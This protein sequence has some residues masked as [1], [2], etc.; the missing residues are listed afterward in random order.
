[1]IPATRASLGHRLNQSIVQPDINA[2]NFKARFRNFSPTGEKHRTTWRFFWTRDMK[3]SYRFSLVGGRFG[4]SRFIMGT[5][6]L[7]ISS[8]SSRANKLDTWQCAHKLCYIHLC[9]MLISL[10]YITYFHLYFQAG[11]I[12][13]VSS[14]MLSPCLIPLQMT[15][16]CSCTPE[17]THLWFHCL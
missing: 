10:L 4:N 6:S 16:H 1:M 5:R 15:G 12:N 9:Q 13:N 7:R 14:D 11:F 8:L 3:Y 2:G 17:K